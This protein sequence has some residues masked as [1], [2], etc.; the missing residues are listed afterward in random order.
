MA[1]KEVIV[2]GKPAVEV[3]T[4]AE[5]A[6]ALDRGIPIAAPP[7]IAAAFGFPVDQDAHE[8]NDEL[9]AEAVDSRPES[10]PSN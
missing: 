4:E 9:S 5:F 1:I 7:E 8:S 6:R 3:D 2:D 10:E